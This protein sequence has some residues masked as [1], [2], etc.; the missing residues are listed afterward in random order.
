MN[1]KNNTDK[2]NSDM[3]NQLVF[4]HGWKYFEL[5]ANQRISL[6]RY[7]IIFFSLYVSGVGF[8]L[9]KCDLPPNVINYFIVTISIIFI[10]VTLIF[11]VL[12]CRNRKLI[13]IAEKS[14][15]NFEEKQFQNP[16]QQIF[17]MKKKEDTNYSGFFSH[18]NSFKCL[19]IIT[20]ISAFILICYSQ[21]R[22]YTNKNC[23]SCKITTSS[24]IN[25]L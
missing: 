6:F 13:Y 18:T 4:E 17:T 20:I 9:T 10:L 12:D 2:I 23:N 25:H 3:N 14:L 22:V 24:I 5:H 21:S 11:W 7:Y 1:K 19:Y 15:C 16:E 8:L